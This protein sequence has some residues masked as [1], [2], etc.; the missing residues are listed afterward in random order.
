VAS[1]RCVTATVEW[2]SKEETM[3]S[4]SRSWVAE[5]WARAGG[6]ATDAYRAA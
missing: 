4:R 6:K 1:V 2:L 3:W 5:S